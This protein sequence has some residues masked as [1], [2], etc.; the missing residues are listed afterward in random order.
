MIARAAEQFE[1]QI[2]VSAGKND[3]IA[4]HDAVVTGDGLVGEVTKVAQQRRR[5]SR[6]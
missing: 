4:K 5:R 3:G 1:Q 6:C 2:V